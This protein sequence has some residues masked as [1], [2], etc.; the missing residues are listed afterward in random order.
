[1]IQLGR[2]ELSKNQSLSAFD[3]EIS[4][5]GLYKYGVD[6]NVGDMVEKQSADNITNTMRI[7]EHIFVS[8]KDGDRSYPTLSID[9]VITPGSWLS[10]DN[11]K[12]WDDMG[13]TE[14]WEGA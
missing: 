9:Q 2:D 6:Y 3:G 13:A 4:Q 14:Y 8:D 11:N 12:E 1:M 7:T 10:W 5:N